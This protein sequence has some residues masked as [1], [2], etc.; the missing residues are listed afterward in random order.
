M[1]SNIIL[2]AQGIQRAFGSEPQSLYYNRQVF[3]MQSLIVWLNTPNGL[4]KIYVHNF[5]D[6]GAKKDYRY[7]CMLNLSFYLLHEYDN[8][9]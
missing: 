9:F 6:V 5:S 7:T 4:E 3:P 2:V 1:R 8:Y